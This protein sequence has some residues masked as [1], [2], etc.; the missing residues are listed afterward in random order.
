[1]A[2]VV[3]NPFATD[4][5]RDEIVLSCGNKVWVRQ[6]LSANARSSFQRALIQMEMDARTGQVS[7]KNLSWEQN[8]ILVCQAYLIGW[9]FVDEHGQPIPYRREDVPGFKEDLLDEISR[10]IDRLQD[11]RQKAKEG[12]GETSEGR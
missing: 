6:T 11:A 2:Q 10:G 1:M 4:D 5:E 9:D 3:Y 12:K 7:V 8:A